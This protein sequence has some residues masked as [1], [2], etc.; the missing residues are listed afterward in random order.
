VVD[1]GTTCCAAPI[2]T[3]A[4]SRYVGQG[5]AW[6][7]CVDDASLSRGGH[8]QGIKRAGRDTDTDGDTDDEAPAGGRRADRLLPAGMA[9]PNGQWHAAGQAGGHALSPV[10]WNTVVAIAEAK[11]APITPKRPKGS[12]PHPAA[13]PMT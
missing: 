9:T 10:V 12:H 11:S 5:R 3:S 1:A 4:P 6:H 8:V 2:A 7:A 13:P